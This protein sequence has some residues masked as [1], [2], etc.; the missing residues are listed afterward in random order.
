MATLDQIF[1]MG[2]GY[3]LNFSDKT[4]AEFFAGEINVDINDRMYYVEGGSK[5]KR[6]RYHLK[7]ADTETAVKTLQALWEH[8]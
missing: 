4:F 7:Q 5:G 3:V 1:E 6:L 8:R 2:S